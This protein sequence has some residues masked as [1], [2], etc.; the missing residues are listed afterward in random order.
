MNRP[1][2]SSNQPVPASD[3]MLAVVV[4]NWN[5]R[6]D[7][8]TCVQALL[9]HGPEN[10]RIIVVDNGSSDNSVEAIRTLASEVIVLE[11]TDNTGFSRG[12]NEGIQAALR[13]GA[14][15][16]GILNNDAIV[17]PG[18][19]EP[20]IAA[21]T[22]TPGPIAVSPSIFFRDQP[23]KEWFA[24]SRYD[25]TFG[26]GVHALDADSRRLPFYLPGCALFASSE[27]WCQ[28]GLLDERFFLNFEDLEWSRRAAALG[29]RLTIVP[30]SRV[31]H[32]VS[33]SIARIGALS[34]YLYARNGVM[35]SRLP[36][37]PKAVEIM[38]FVWQ[39]VVL[40]HIRMVRRREPGALMA[41][42]F[43]AIGIFHGRRER[44]TGAPKAWLQTLAG[45]QLTKR[46]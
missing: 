35:L 40:P 38:P 45:K 46:R 22:A 18:Y 10:Q 9:A 33:E 6:E 13:M 14:K 29:V 28:V 23:T 25:Q 41:L 43:A 15:I 34:T 26:Q 42:P 17:Q 32:G 3:S 36:F 12:N 44:P 19:A 5:G 4:L 2:R 7:T 27:V 24:G 20:L 31:H 11:L 16:I 39:S 21:I 30:Q 1:D 37:E 8:V